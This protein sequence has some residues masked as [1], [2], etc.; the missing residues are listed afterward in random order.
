MAAAAIRVVSRLPLITAIGRQVQRLA[1]PKR[2]ALGEADL[3]TGTEIIV[4]LARQVGGYIEVVGLL[5]H[6]VDRHVERVARGRGVT[7]RELEVDHAEQSRRG[8][9]VG[10]LLIVGIVVE[11][12][13]PEPHL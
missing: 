4:R 7:G 1:S 3:R 13:R 2:I 11:L 12:S 9:Q 6:T 10:R 5:E 8:E